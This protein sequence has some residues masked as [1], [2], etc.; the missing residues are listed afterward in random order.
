MSQ[1]SAATAIV[2]YEPSEPGKPI[3]RHE[4]VTI[5]RT[6]PGPN[7][8]LVR[9]LASG[10]CHTDI[11]C[12]SVPTGVFGGYP[13]VLGHEGSGYVVAVGSSVKSVNVGD[14]VL[15]SYTY[16]GKCDLC[17]DNEQTY[18]QNFNVENAHCG[19]NVWDAK[20][21]EVGGKFFGQSSFASLSLV[22]E[23]SI[24]NVKG[25]VKDGDDEELKK[26][27]PLGCGLMTGSGAITTT[28]KARPQDGILITGMGA[29]GLGA[30]MAAKVQGCKTIIAVDRI[31][32]RLELAKEL[33]ATHVLDV[34]SYDI[35]REDYAN[36][37][38]IV[39]TDLAKDGQ[40]NY[41]LDTTGIIPVMNACI[42]SLSKRGKLL[43]IGIPVTTTTSIL[44]L[45][46]MDFFG[47]TKRFETNYL[48]DCLAR[49]QIP[50]MIQWYREGKFPFDRFIKFY[51]AK[52]FE[53]A[54]KDMKGETVKPILI[55]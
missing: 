29:V 54:L 41:A 30:V 3:W 34:S 35:S 43:Q 2:A 45:D 50:R 14:P 40:I 22:E 53:T 26:F 39:I 10:V 42:K 6:D 44:P 9:I 46:A 36:D 47:G 24:V 23:R 31:A 38:S 49:E 28:A 4:P 37:I 32:S 15:L 11:V 16:C 52:D 18:C 51:A 20:D 13:K 27:S 48:G 7:E 8:V 21:G 55:H 17:E 25:L 5:K 12:G 1:S 19:V 33:G